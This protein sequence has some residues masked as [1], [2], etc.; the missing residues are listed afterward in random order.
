[1]W[2]TKDILADRAGWQEMYATMISSNP[3]TSAM[4]AEM[5]KIDGLPVLVETTRMMGTVEVKSR[6]AVTSALEQE[7][8]AGFYDVP[9]GFTEKPFDPLASMSM[10]AGGGRPRAQ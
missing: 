2:V 3:F 10:H 5:R 8:A 6:E 7:P 4:A 9:A 1:M